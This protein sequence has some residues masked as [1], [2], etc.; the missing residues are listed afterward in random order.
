MVGA[1]LYRRMDLE[2]LRSARSNDRAK[3]FHKVGKISSAKLVC[4]LEF[5]CEIESF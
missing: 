2:V 1:A 4:W 5:C 3:G